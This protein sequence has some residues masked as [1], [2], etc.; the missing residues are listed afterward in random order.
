MTIPPTCTSCLWGASQTCVNGVLM[1]VH[2]CVSFPGASVCVC[3]CVCVRARA[4]PTGPPENRSDSV[5]TQVTWMKK[6][7]TSF[8]TARQSWSEREGAREKTS[9]SSGYQVHAGTVDVCNQRFLFFSATK[10]RFFF[11]DFQTLR[12]VFSFDGNTSWCGQSWW[13]FGFPVWRQAI[14]GQTH[15]SVTDTRSQRHTHTETSPG[16]EDRACYHACATGRYL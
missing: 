9:S 2:K 4:H 14:P 1:W 12:K 10:W 3:V 5:L 7:R 6:Q 16:E 15:T 11:S 8:T 13:E